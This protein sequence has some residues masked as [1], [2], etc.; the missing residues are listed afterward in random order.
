MQEY[1]AATGPSWFP[2]MH[3]ARIHS[4]PPIDLLR[5]A[6]PDIATLHRQ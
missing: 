2:Q 6:W 1:G 5:A 3:Q 4:Q